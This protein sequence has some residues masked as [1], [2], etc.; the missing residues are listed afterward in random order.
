MTGELDVPTDHTFCVTSICTYSTNSIDM[1][2]EEVYSIKW[3]PLTSLG[4]SFWLWLM[5]ITNVFFT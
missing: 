1:P 5:V 2:P 3:A 4:S